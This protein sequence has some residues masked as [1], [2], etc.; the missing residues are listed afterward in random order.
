MFVLLY[1]LCQYGL[2][3]K[4]K[5]GFVTIYCI[6]DLMGTYMEWCVGRKI[7]LIVKLNVIFI[8]NQSITIQKGGLCRVF[9]DPLITLMRATSW[10]NDQ[11]IWVIWGINIRSST[12]ASA[13]QLNKKNSK[14]NIYCR[15]VRYVIIYTTHVHE[16]VEL[17]YVVHA[18]NWCFHRKTMKF[19]MRSWRLPSI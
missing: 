4:E 19:I 12:M 6:F 17:H 11:W 1:A 10:R 3:V 13:N 16:Y 14:T 7:Q 9:R 18:I 15:W 2:F 5:I 8:H